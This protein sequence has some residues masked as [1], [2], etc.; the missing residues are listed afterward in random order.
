MK[1]NNRLQYINPDGKYWVWYIL[2][3]LLFYIAF[4]A[5]PLLDSIRL[6]LYTG[7]VGNKVF[8]GFQNFKTLFLDMKHSQRYWNAMGNT[9]IFFG[10][11]IQKINKR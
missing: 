8:V 10:Y 5:Y 6:S 3:A 11:F 9:S 7:N 4:M 2:P 1:K